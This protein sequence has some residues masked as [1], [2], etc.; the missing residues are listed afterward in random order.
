MDNYRDV[1]I[2][3]VKAVG[4]SGTET[5]DLAINE[6]LTALYIYF[7]VKNLAAVCN[8]V[9]PPIVISK[10]EI[11]DGGKVYYSCSGPEAMAAAVYDTAVWPSHFYNEGSA[12]GQYVTI[13]VLFGRYL[14]DEEYAFS[15]GRLL[16]PQLK[17]TW[18]YNALHDATA[19]YQLGVR[20]KAMQG[21][22]ASSL[23]LMTKSVRTFTSAASGIEI[24]DVPVDYDIRRLFVRNGPGN[25]YW[26]EVLAHFKLDCDVGKLIVFD[27]DQNRFL[28]MIRETFPSVELQMQTIC[29][30]NEW[31]RSWLGNT[32]GVTCNFAVGGIIGGGWSA[33]A[34][35]W[36]SVVSTDAGALTTDQV[37][38]VSV[39]GWL[40]HSTLAY[41]F[42]R[43]DDPASW[44][45]AHRYGQVRLELTQGVVAQSIGVLLQRPTPLP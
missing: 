7:H 30:S 13:P 4:Q 26:A 17:I 39:R 25:R 40:P 38:T 37:A 23:A 22:P 3:P 11:V 24:T 5:V 21:V 42:G 44:F 43:S 10:I 2:L 33:N 27:M 34:Y 8:D 41:Q 14:G 9:P 12:A 29:D 19:A 18:E 36:Q 32:M 28:D 15:P 20:V 6:P 16:N 1:E 35:R 45:K 31:H